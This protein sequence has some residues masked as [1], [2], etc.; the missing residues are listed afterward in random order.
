MSLFPPLPVSGIQLNAAVVSL[1]LRSASIV[2]AVLGGAPAVVR[3]QRTQI[4]ETRKQI[5]G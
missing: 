2:G 5:V 3:R 4:L 1:V